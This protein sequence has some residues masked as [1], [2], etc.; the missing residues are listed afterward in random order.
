VGFEV[1]T[2]ISQS[3]YSTVQHAW[4]APG[5]MGILGAA[6]ACAKLLKLPLDQT[7][8]ALGMAVPMAGGV[9][10]NFGTMTKS[11]HVG[12][13]GRNAVLAAKLAAAGFTA[14]G[15]A[16]ESE[17]GYYDAYYR[18]FPEADSPLDS[19]GQSWELVESGLRIKPYPCGG[20]AHTAIDAALSLQ[21]ELR[22]NDEIEAISV[23]VTERVLGRIV[24]G[25]P[26]TE[27]EAKFSMPYLVAR[28]L[29]DGRVGLDAFT[30]EAIQ[31][32]RLL[33]LAEKVQMRLGKDLKS[34]KAG[35]PSR[36]TIHLRDGRTLFRQVDTPKGGEEVPMTYGELL[37][38][39]HECAA[40]TMT[41]S[42]ADLV[43]EAIHCLDATPNLRILTTLLRGDAA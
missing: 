6:A 39:F 4:H 16:I 14:N 32:R 41:R 11:L 12:Q 18:V 23:E 42:Y 27:L 1:T 29:I 20:L 8:M 22:V 34:T 15:E 30:D 17:V 13:A 19:L 28:A 2:K 9:E 5:N 33:A 3:L 37:A 7:R 25:I 43:V 36:V 31:E 35:R 10:A 26:R 38:K 21:G 24:F 40:R